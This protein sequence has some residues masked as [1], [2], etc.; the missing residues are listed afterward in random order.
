MAAKKAPMKKMSAPA[1]AAPKKTGTA[2]SSKLT[3]SQKAALAKSAKNRTDKNGS[4]GMGM[5]KGSVASRAQEAGDR[6]NM[7]NEISNYPGQETK[8]RQGISNAQILRNMETNLANGK[9]AF[10]AIA[11][12]YGVTGLTY[13]ATSI[14]EK[15]GISPKPKKKK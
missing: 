11:K 4:T 8:R 9:K 7:N 13:R 3:A 5:N 14:D 2:D 10:D 12:K 15:V 1:K 6:A